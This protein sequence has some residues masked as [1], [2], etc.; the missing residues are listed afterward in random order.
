MELHI[1]IDSH[2]QDKLGAFIENLPNIFNNE[3]EI[4]Y[5][6]RNT[7]KVFE[8]N[9]I[10]IN[11]KSFKKPHIINQFVY[12]TF[13]K[14]KAKR[15]YLYAKRLQSLG[16]KTPSPIAYIEHRNFFNLKGSA[17]LS[18]NEKFDGLLQELKRGNIE[19]KRN[20]IVQ[21]AQFTASIHEKE[22]LHLDYSPGNILYKK[23]GSNYIFYLVDLNRMTFDNPIDLDT[24]C[25][26][27]RRLW[28][29]DAMIT[30]FVKEYAKAR[31]FDE[32]ECL[33]KT[34]YY[35]ARFWKYFQRKHPNES[36]YIG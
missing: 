34:F 28:G 10:S 9:G 11:V 13:R 26:N 31:N 4:V 21:F 5:N 14:S 30:L 15:S 23:D 2:Y 3:G 32:K 17:Y 36:P 24:A 8:A 7:I 18:V 12:A 25:F 20:L 6:G 1:V 35:R 29:S 27:F 16:I 22:V 19:E 33:D